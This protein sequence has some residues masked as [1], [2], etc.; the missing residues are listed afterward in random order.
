MIALAAIYVLTSTSE[1]NL[2]PQLSEKEAAQVAKVDIAK[3][4]AELQVDMEVIIEIAAGIIEL[5][6]DLEE[7]DETMV[8]EL[9][10]RLNAKV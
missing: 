5:Y 4:F 1:D 10:R 2:I 7:Y 8:P 3:W 9:V 6:R